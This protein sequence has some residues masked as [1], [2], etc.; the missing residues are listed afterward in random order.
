LGRVDDAMA[1]IAEIKRLAADLRL[2][3][4]TPDTSPVDNMRIDEQLK[5]VDGIVRD[6]LKVKPEVKPEPDATKTEAL[7]VH[8]GE[9]HR[10]VEEHPS[11]D[12][13]SKK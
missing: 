9:K 12:K 11:S 6:T 3:L 13:P 1:K 2:F 8:E 4:S 7:P 10:H 5:E